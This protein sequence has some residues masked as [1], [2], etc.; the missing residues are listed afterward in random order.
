MI[1][2]PILVCLTHGI[3]PLILNTKDVKSSSIEKGNEMAEKYRGRTEAVSISSLQLS[4]VTA[5]FKV[6]IL[7]T[8]HSKHEKF[9]IV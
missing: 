1:I 7:E 6:C 3:V 8:D 2:N 4:K 9:Q 5:D